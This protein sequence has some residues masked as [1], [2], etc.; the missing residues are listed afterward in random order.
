MIRYGLIG[1]PLTHS[2]SKRYFTTRFEE[3]GISDQFQYEIYEIESPDQMRTLFQQDPDLRGLNVTIPH[4]LGVM[5]LLDDLDESAKRVGAVNVIKRTDQDQLIGFNSDW[6]GFQ[7]SLR[8]ASQGKALS[9][10]LILGYGGAAKAIEVAL[11]DEGIHVYRV[12]RQDGAD[13]ISYDQANVLLP[14]IQLIVNCTPLGTYPNVTTYPPIDYS[15]LNSQHLLFD[16]VYNPEETEFLKRGKAQGATIQNG[17]DML[18]YQAERSWDIWQNPYK[19]T[20]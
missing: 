17:Y 1:Y 9:K 15:K 8:Q 14:E 4:K 19:S 6:Y 11:E 2:F 3:L 7:T 18:V 12:S 16:L 13:R 10:A 20:Y 5:P